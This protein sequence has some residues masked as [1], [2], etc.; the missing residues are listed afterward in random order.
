[1]TS[2]W[3]RLGVFFFCV[4]ERGLWRD[5]VKS[6]KKLK[7]I[8]ETNELLEKHTDIPMSL[9]SIEIPWGV[10]P[11]KSNIRLSGHLLP[12][13]DLKVAE[14]L[15]GRLPH[16]ATGRGLHGNFARNS[17]DDGWNPL[18]FQPCASHMMR[19]RFAKPPYPNG[20]GSIPINTIFRGMNIHL[21]AILMFTRGT[22]FWHI[23]KY[24]HTL[25]VIV[26]SE[27][28]SSWRICV[29]YRWRVNRYANT[30]GDLY[31]G[32]FRSCWESKI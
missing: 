29:R 30:I 14:R 6:Q 1:M 13:G 24:D 22:R 20:Y 5:N 15:A 2:I 18:N 32:K 4:G 7:K 26:C 23:P 16:E 10:H 21:P 11:E 27:P 31:I 17:W 12:E 19:S 8:A 3:Y 25:R 28:S 9:K